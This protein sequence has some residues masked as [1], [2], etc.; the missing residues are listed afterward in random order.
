MGVMNW[1]VQKTMINEAKRIARKVKDRY[2]SIKKEHPDMDDN[3]LFIKMVFEEDEFNNLG[4]ETKEYVRNCCQTVEGLSYMFAMDMGSLKGFMVFRLIQFTKYMDHYLY[5]LGFKK[6]SKEQKEAV[7][8][9]LNIYVED[10]EKI[11]K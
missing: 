5:S 6:Q 2:D 7:L 9:T 1:I 10:W 8:K 4:A 3:D 11:I